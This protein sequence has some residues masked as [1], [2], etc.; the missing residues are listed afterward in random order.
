LEFVKDVAPTALTVRVKTESVT[1]PITRVVYTEQLARVAKNEQKR[2]TLGSLRIMRPHGPPLHS[3]WGSERGEVELLP[4]QVTIIPDSKNELEISIHRQSYR[5]RVDF[6]TAPP[7][8]IGAALYL[9]TED[10][11]PWLVNVPDRERSEAWYWASTALAVV[12]LLQVYKFTSEHRWPFSRPTFASQMIP[13]SPAG[14]QSNLKDALIN[15]LSPGTTRQDAELPLRAATIYM[16]S[17]SNSHDGAQFLAAYIPS[18]DSTVTLADAIVREHQELLKEFAPERGG[19][20]LLAK[21]QHEEQT[22]DH[23]VF[24]GLIYIYHEKLLTE[25]E[26]QSIDDVAATQGVQVILRDPSFLTR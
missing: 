7:G 6:V 23:V 2:L 14:P 19:I 5:C 4:G 16:A 17:F 3:V 9:T 8:A 1:G 12:L 13:A 10:R 15:D 26:M 18:T 25:Q 22:T 21:G 20:K 24:T 11:S